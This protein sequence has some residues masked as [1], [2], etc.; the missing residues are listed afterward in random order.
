MSKLS[1][2]LRSH[3][4]RIAGGGPGDASYDPETLDVE[5]QAADR[6]EKLEAEV[7]ELRSVIREVWHW[8]AASLVE[9]G[10]SE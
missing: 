6:I 9:E 2:H 4:Y 3:A 8:T 1:E 7:E 10:A 5:C